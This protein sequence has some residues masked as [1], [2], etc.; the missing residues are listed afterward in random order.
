MVENGTATWN[1]FYRIRESDFEADEQLRLIGEFLKDH[2]EC[3]IDIKS[4]ADVETGNP[5]INMEYSRLRFEKAVKAL[6]DDEVLLH[7]SLQVIMA[8]QYSLS[9]ITTRTALASSSQQV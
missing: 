2:R 3:K 8:T 9:L 7:L 6:T 4:Y 1:V 5:K